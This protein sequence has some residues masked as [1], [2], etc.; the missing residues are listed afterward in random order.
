MSE[1]AETKSDLFENTWRDGKRVKIKELKH[2]KCHR[3]RNGPVTMTDAERPQQSWSQSYKF[4]GIL[5]DV[6]HNIS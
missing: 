6:A 4:A 2:I 3:F 1:L 5:K